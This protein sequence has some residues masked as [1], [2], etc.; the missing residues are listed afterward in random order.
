MTGL[1]Y[2]GASSGDYSLALHT[3][4]SGKRRVTAERTL[5][6]LA[7]KA[8]TVTL[9]SPMVEEIGRLLGDAASKILCSIDD[10]DGFSLDDEEKSYTD[11]RWLDRYIEMGERLEGENG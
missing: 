11:R 2:P 5:L 4:P 3:G 6:S 1:P 8:D 7:G 10:N 9:P